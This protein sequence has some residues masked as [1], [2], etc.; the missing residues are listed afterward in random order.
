MTAETKTPWLEKVGLSRPELRAWALYDWANSGMVTVIITAVYPIYFSSVASA[1]ADPAVATSRHATATWI[2]MLFVA[3]LAPILGTLA[4]VRGSRKR[5]LGIA[6]AIGVGAVAALFFVRQGDW[7]LA[8]FCFGLANAAAAASFV[9]YDSLLPAVAKPAEFDRV[10]TSAYAL[11]YFGGGLL[12]ALNLA[13]ILKPAWFGL[14]GG[15]GTLPTRLA[16]LSVA[17]WWL[18]FS[19]PLLRRVPEPAPELQP[20]EL[21]LSA[22]RI[23]TGRLLRTFVDL[24]GFREAFL[25]MLAFFLYNDAVGTIIRMAAS[26]SVE[27]GLDQSQ[28]IASILVVQFVGVPFAFL[29]GALAGRIGAKRSILISIGV[30]LVVCALAYRLETA[31][32]FFVMAFLVGVVQGAVQALSRSLFASMIPKERAGEFFGLFSVLEKFAG[33]L[34]PLTFGVVVARYGSSRPAI[35]VLVLFFLIGGAIL[36][37]VDVDRGRARA[38]AAEAEAERLRLA[39]VSATAGS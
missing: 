7:L 24:V 32:D 27:L 19:L 6:L 14:D 23:T 15:D 5:F 36:L 9:F 31:T 29:F 11:G 8:V 28:V 1:G 3:L 30:Y 37:R 26:F 13:W 33:I 35:L 38:R 12:L 4:D 22:A 20:S 2:S 16:F 10:S 21:G 34:G 17:V 39:R 25:M 18:L